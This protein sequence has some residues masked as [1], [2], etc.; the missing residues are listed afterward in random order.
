[1]PPTTS[2]RAYIA[3]KTFLE[4]E[5]YSEDSETASPERSSAIQSGWEAALR[6]TRSTGGGYIN[7]FKFSD[8]PQLVKFLDAQPFAVYDQHWVER[9][10]KR[11]FTCLQ[12]ADCPLCDARLKNAAKR[13]VAFGIVNLSHEEG[14][15]VQILTVSPKTAQILARYNDDKTAGPLD[16]LYYAVSKSGERQQTVFNFRPVKPRDL[17]EDYGFDPTQTESMIAALEAPTSKA[18]SF[19]TRDQLEEIAQEISGRPSR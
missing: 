10:G 1:M 19:N 6:P 17:E 5:L 9:A 4:D 2:P 13:K 12:S 15:T 16:R 14:P 18:I 8:E 7:D 11:S 3:D